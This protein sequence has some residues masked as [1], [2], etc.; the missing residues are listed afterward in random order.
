MRIGI[1]LNLLAPDNGGVTNYT[2]TLLRNWAA[3]APEHPMVLFSFAHNE[4]LLSTLPPEARRHEIRLQTQEEALLHFDKIDVYFCPFGTLWPRPVRKPAVLTFHDMQ[5]RFYPEFFTDKEMEE[6]FFH[7]DWSLRMADAV[8][9]ISD[10]T[11]EMVSRL[12]GIRRSACHVVHHV[13][14]ELP[15]PVRPAACDS[16]TRRPF[17]FYPANLWRHKNHGRVLRAL[18]LAVSQGLEVDLVCTGSLLGR[19]SDWDR[20]VR[21][22]GLEHRVHHLGKVSRAEISWLFRNAQS[23]FFPSLFEGFGIPL[24]EAMQSGCPIACGRNT[25]QPEVARESALYFDAHRVESIAAAL[26][27]I[28]RDEPL[29]QRLIVAGRERIQAFAIERQIRGHLDAFAAACRRHTRVRQ[30]W[31]EKIRLPHSHRMRRLLTDREK[32]TAAAL[33][34]ERTQVPVHF[35]SLP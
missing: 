23:L 5:E 10:F 26:L 25:S 13:P 14:D 1:G 21:A 34:R 30:W 2:L 3:H 33:L 27:R 12:V 20:S 16:E 28:S 24:L 8:I 11:R 31:N 32:Q 19:D 15:E 7:Y 6:R 29:R 9:T 17:L 35:E 22:L 4:P 18:A